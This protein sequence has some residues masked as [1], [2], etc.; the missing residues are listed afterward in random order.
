MITTRVITIFL[1]MLGTAGI[2]A[3]QEVPHAERNT[4]F[5][6][7]SF[8]GQMWSSEGTFSPVEKNNAL[9]QSYFEQTASIYSTWQ[10]SLT[11]TPYAA[12]GIVF[13]T[14]GYSWNNKLQPSAGVKVNKFFRHGIV[15]VGAAYMYEDRWSAPKEF[16]TGGKTNYILDWFGWQL[17]S[18]SRNRFPGS[19]WAIIGQYSPVERGNLIEQGYVTQGFVLHR[20]NHA[21]IVPYADITLSHD[22]M[23][24]DWENKSM[25]GGGVKIAVSKGELYT[26]FGAG[27][28]QESHFISGLSATGLKIFVNTSYAWHLFGRQGR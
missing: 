9:S 10:N 26:E 12:V 21:A 28:V 16:R 11:V 24:F 8:S 6:A 19:T 2:V 1:L 4:I 3:A 13:D 25:F 18:N 17:V 7:M 22:S 15:S 20:F 23:K 14:K 5:D 27:I